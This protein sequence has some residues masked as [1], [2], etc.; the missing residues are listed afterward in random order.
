[1]GGISHVTERVQ[2]L[3]WLV[4]KISTLYADRRL[5]FRGLIWRHSG[6]R[7]HRTRMLFPDQPSIHTNN[8]GLQ[9]K[10]FGFMLHI[11]TDL[12]A[13]WHTSSPPSNFN[14]QFIATISS[15]VYNVMLLVANPPCR[16]FLLSFWSEN[17]PDVLLQGL[18]RYYSIYLS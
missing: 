7:I 11:F 10:Y 9:H 13:T 12:P 15:L 16:P 2:V 8:T 4:S 14:M 1:M 5:R 6:C 18:H 3:P 17:R